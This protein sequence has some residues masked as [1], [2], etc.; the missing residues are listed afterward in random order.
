MGGWLPSHP[1]QST[2]QKKKNVDTVGIEPTT[3]HNS[4]TQCEASII[5]NI[6]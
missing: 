6:H 4:A 3:T 1:H 5:Y 2:N